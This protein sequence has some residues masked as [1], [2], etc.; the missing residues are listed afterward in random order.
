MKSNNTDE[1]NNIA[2]HK[3]N[4]F[5]ENMDPNELSGTNNNNMDYSPGS[6]NSNAIIQNSTPYKTNPVSIPDEASTREL[7]E[8]ELQCGTC[9]KI[10]PRGSS[11][12]SYCTIL[13]D[14]YLESFLDKE[15]EH[16]KTVKIRAS[17]EPGQMYWCKS[18]IL[19]FEK[20]WSLFQHVADKAK[21]IKVQRWD[22]KAH[23][24]WLETVAALLAGLDLG[25]FTPAKIRNDLRNLLADQHT[26][27]EEMEEAAFA[28]AAFMQMLG[29][30]NVQNFGGVNPGAVFSQSGFSNMLANPMA[31]GGN[32]SGN[33]GNGPWR[34][35][36]RDIMRKLDQFNRQLYRSQNTFGNNNK[37][38]GNNGGVSSYNSG[39]QTYYTGSMNPRYGQN[40]AGTHYYGQNGQRTSRYHNATSTR[41]SALNADSPSYIPAGLKEAVITAVTGTGDSALNDVVNDK[42]DIVEDTNDSKSDKQEEQKS[43]DL[44]AD[45]EEK[46]LENKSLKT[47]EENKIS[48]PNENTDPKAIENEAKEEYNDPKDTSVVHV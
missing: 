21:G 33:I 22:K 20:P 24:D 2:D 5:K 27:D 13:K 9:K 29:G 10:L 35:Q 12:E 44:K 18:C 26:M 39:G 42:V 30:N 23:L 15:G 28:Y 8:N 46:L 43:N 31:P 3:E 45:D 34:M 48:G 32:N 17:L 16:I 47:M 6:N 7:K 37:G 11:S 40:N 38:P 14:H 19:I 25:L 41:S 36:Q 4:D 1:Y